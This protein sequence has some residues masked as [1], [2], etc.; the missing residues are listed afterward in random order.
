MKLLLLSIFLFSIACSKE[1]PEPPHVPT[2][3]EKTAQCLPNYQE[4]TR[5]SLSI[6]GKIE[7]NCFQNDLDNL[8]SA[9]EVITKLEQEVKTSQNL[10]S[11][12]NN[13][14]KLQEILAY[15]RTKHI[16]SKPEKG[17][18]ISDVTFMQVQGDIFSASAG[19]GKGFGGEEETLAH[20]KNAL[21]SIRDQLKDHAFIVNEQQ[22]RP[23][24]NIKLDILP[25]GQMPYPDL[26]QTLLN[27]LI[28]NYEN[29]QKLMELFHDQTKLTELRTEL[30]KQLGELDSNQSL[31]LPGGWNGHAVNYQ[32]T[33][34]DDAS[35]TFRVYNEGGGIGEYHAES[36]TGYKQQYF[37]FVEVRGIA[38]ENITSFVFLNLLQKIAIEAGS[39]TDFYELVLPAIDGKQEPVT[40]DAKLFHDMQNAGTC[41]YFSTPMVMENTVSQM[42]DAETAS[43]QFIAPQIE[44]LINAKTIR[45][46]A[47]IANL[48]LASRLNLL[49]KGLVYFS[50]DTLESSNRYVIDAGTLAAANKIGS[51]IFEQIT[52]AQNNLDSNAKSST[53]KFSDTSI[54]QT[55]PLGNTHGSVSNLRKISDSA[56][57]NRI[58]PFFEIKPTLDL[59]QIFEELHKAVTE[60]HYVEVMDATEKLALNLSL[61]PQNPKEE[62]LSY[63]AKI[64]EIYLFA[65]LKRAAHP[66]NEKRVTAIQFLTSLTLLSVGDAINQKLGTGIDSLY[67]AR[68][69]EF[70]FGDLSIFEIEDPKWQWQLKLL[71]DYYRSEHQKAGDDYLSFYG[72][73][74]LPV[75]VNTHRRIYE[76]TPP[77]KR[78]D[79]HWGLDIKWK[80]LDWAL[81]YARKNFAGKI[82]LAEQTSPGKITY[83]CKEPELKE[84]QV[85][86]GT[87]NTHESLE[88]T[89]RISEY[90]TLRRIAIES[91]GLYS[92]HPLPKPFYDLRKLSGITDY[93][94]TA[95]IIRDTDPKDLDSEFY[96]SQKK[97]ETPVQES[98][99]V[100]QAG[101]LCQIGVG[102]AQK[103]PILE[104]M[105]D[106]YVDFKYYVFFNQKHSRTSYEPENL[107]EFPEDKNQNYISPYL[108]LK[109]ASKP[110]EKFKSTQKA[111]EEIVRLYGELKRNR[112]EP[113]KLIVNKLNGLISK[114]ISRERARAILGIS[115]FKN[116]Q[117]IQ[118]LAYFTRYPNLLHLPV[119]QRLFEKLILDPGLLLSQL[120]NNSLL[121][122][123]LGKFTQQ[124][125]NNFH[126]IGD[127]QGMAF[128]LRINQLFR[129]YANFSRVNTAN[130]LMD[131]R[132]KLLELIET[133]KD[134]QEISFLYRNL[135][136][137]Y[138]YETHLSPL[139][140]QNL[141]LAVMKHK[142][143]PITNPDY[144]DVFS[145]KSIENILISHAEQILK[146]TNNSMLNF[147]ASSLSNRKIE[148]N[149]KNTS[150]GVYNSSDNRLTISVIRGLFL[151]SGHTLTAFPVPLEIY[152]KAFGNVKPPISATIL[153]DNSSYSWTWKGQ[154]QA[155]GREKDKG[156][157]IQ[158]EQEDGRWFELLSDSQLKPLEE[159]QAY[160]PNTAYWQ[161]L[162]SKDGKIHIESNNLEIT[163]NGQE[164]ELIQRKNSSSPYLINV[165]EKSP[166]RIFEHIE[167]WNK[168]YLWSKDKKEVDEVE[169]P[170]LKLAFKVQNGRLI[171]GNITDHV[172]STEQFSQSLSEPVS[173]LLCEPKSNPEQNRL[174]LTPLNRPALIDQTK[175]NEQTKRIAAFNPLF[176][177]NHG[178][179]EYV[180]YNINDSNLEQRVLPKTDTGRYY[181][182]LRKFYQHQ[183][184]DAANLIRS[185]ASELGVFTNSERLVLN[186]IAD[187]NP[188]D[189]DPRAYAISLL[190]EAWLLKDQVYYQGFLGDKKS[191]ERAKAKYLEYLKRVEHVDRTLLGYDNEALIASLLERNQTQIIA[192]LEPKLNKA[193]NELKNLAE[194]DYTGRNTKKAEIKNLE[195]IITQLKKQQHQFQSRSSAIRAEKA[196]R[197]FF[198]T[199]L[200]YHPTETKLKLQTAYWWSYSIRDLEPIV[201]EDDFGL[202]YQIV[203]GE[204][205][206]HQQARNWLLKTLGFK[207][208]QVGFL[209]S[210]EL[211]AEVMLWLRT[212]V[213]AEGYGTPQTNAYSFLLSLGFERI[214]NRPHKRYKAMKSW[215]IFKHEL[216][217]AINIC[218]E[219]IQLSLKTGRCDHLSAVQYMNDV[220]NYF[221]HKIIPTKITIT[222]PIGLGQPYL[223]E[224]GTPSQEIL[225]SEVVIIAEDPLRNPLLST[226]DIEQFFTVSTITP[227]EQASDNQKLAELTRQLAK[228]KS[229]N[230]PDIIRTVKN[231]SER[232]TKFVK[233]SQEN[234]KSY[235][236]KNWRELEALPILNLSQRKA[237]LEKL[238]EEILSQGR[239]YAPLFSSG[240]QQQTVHRADMGQQAELNEL[241]HMFLKRSPLP[242]Y[243]ISGAHDLKALDALYNKLANYLIE[244]T[245]VKQITKLKEAITSKNIEDTLEFGRESRQYNPKDHVEYLVFEYYMNLL[246]RK[247]QVEA[248][249]LLQIKDG[250]IRNERHYGALIEMIMGSGKTLVLLPMLSVL[251]TPGQ[252]LNIIMLPEPLIADE[253]RKLSKKLGSSFARGIDVLEFSRQRY[254]GADDLNR[255]Y[256]RLQ[257]AREESR[258]IVTTNSAMQSLFLNFVGRLS[259]Q[260]TEEIAPFIQIFKFLKQYGRL[261]IDEVDLALDILQSHQFSIGKSISLTDSSNLKV[262][263][264][265]AI[266]FYHLLATDPVLCDKI[267][268]SFTHC[269]KNS[270]TQFFTQNSY[271]S[272]KPILIN[273]ILKA[274]PYFV[275]Y[276]DLEVRF[277]AIDKNLAREYLT[278]GDRLVLDKITDNTA[279]NILAVLYEEIQAVFPLTA[280]KK[281][282]VQYGP[283]DSDL[284]AIPYHLGTPMKQSRFGT[285]LEALN[286]TLQMVLESRNFEPILSKE[287]AYLDR[288][289]KTKPTFF[290][291]KFEELGLAGHYEITRI[292]KQDI[293]EIAQKI[294]QPSEIQKQFAL[295]KSQVLKQVRVYPR[296]LVTNAQ[297]YEALFKSVQGLSGTLWN[298][299]T[300]PKIF[301]E[302]EPSTTSEE[303]F[304]TLWRDQEQNAVNLVTPKISD[305][306]TH[307]F[308]GSLIDEAGLFVAH[309][310]HEIAKEIHALTAQKI[311]YYDEANAIKTE[312][313]GTGQI[314]DFAAY[315]DK[316]HT[317]GSD[318]KLQKNMQARMTVDQHTLS[319]NLQQAAWRLR[320]LAKGQKINAFCLTAESQ[321]IMNTRLEEWG[322]K[323]PRAFELGDIILYVVANQETRLGD[324]RVR[325]AKQKIK[326]VIVKQVIHQI[327]SSSSA[328][329][330]LKAYQ[331]GSK[332]FEVNIE[333]SEL[334]QQLGY[335]IKFMS[336]KFILD[337]YEASLLRDNKTYDSLRSEI[338]DLIKQE[339]PKLPPKVLNSTQNSEQ[340]V[341]I[342]SEQETELEAEQ[343]QEVEQELDYSGEPD[344]QPRKV[345]SWNLGPLFVLKNAPVITLEKAFLD[346]GEEFLAHAFDKNILISRNFAPKH[347]VG[348]YAYE[349]FGLYHKVL[350]DVLVLQDA[351]KTQVVILD[352]NDT[353]EWDE[354]LTPK[355]PIRAA[356][357]NLDLGFYKEGSEPIQGNHYEST[358]AQVK[359]FAGVLNYNQV[360]Q[361]YLETFLRTHNPK[362]MLEIFRKEILKHRR[363]TR[364]NFLGSD[365]AGI[366]LKIL[367]SLD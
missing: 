303:T 39:D 55:A 178:S 274:Q 249:D 213:R 355:P 261:T 114:D 271:K 233:N 34:Q 339:N 244:S 298:T 16:L 172:V 85:F 27:K 205:F 65:L 1:K 217:D 168:V 176:G 232:I 170:R 19:A 248:L 109:N 7:A 167:N 82:N 214:N 93:L 235:Q 24:L 43:S 67:Q 86:R 338:Q 56:E 229:S 12:A 366:F 130:L 289:S 228:A 129:D 234:Q 227:L 208:A 147:L 357:Y 44:F 150:K 102:A 351:D 71:Q 90:N 22:S 11:I 221:E 98:K 322:M 209:S 95:P 61:N 257:K 72:F 99:S 76:I 105:N 141:V 28:K 63:L 30:I 18:A 127:L 267:A 41:V 277:E 318:L 300:Y 231:L 45:D 120:Q 135:A 256:A 154:L 26:S 136:E 155:L 344:Y 100:R 201:Q 312:P 50:R 270:Q 363:D 193:E 287:I 106:P 81:A 40:Y 297:V 84:G 281:L 299:D 332:L 348:S 104:S 352:G 25:K 146:N 251:N 174:A 107:V 52:K 166:Y 301:R 268:F 224:I 296:Q 53:P 247:N 51:D 288:L 157:V 266:S 111:H 330:A 119:Y 149:W 198:A 321:G 358:I 195:K 57:S 128:A 180:L 101:C 337:E 152:E 238:R 151:D 210:S 15:C 162:D 38:Y 123:H 96:I 285:S 365:L 8:A 259:D 246:I 362:K 226:Y 64:D 329:D 345:P 20:R 308:K 13:Y 241:I 323:P 197:E 252:W 92:R 311:A 286:Y 240:A 258:T 190:A 340:E 305:I 315:W 54:K 161:Q 342:E 367:G 83:S 169:L 333:K 159:T 115:G 75:G 361:H 112:Q 291:K 314:E 282:D 276:P 326:N 186:W 187:G 158:R 48:S 77:P 364:E 283:I 6:F 255:L 70:L 196:N 73:E 250:Q 139:D 343:E 46:Y 331:S 356:L 280:S 2:E 91:L 125:Y 58:K 306:Y 243:M 220:T 262:L 313:E 202:L 219:E 206:N 9:R 254:L 184:R 108:H 5:N 320:G 317:T 17:P 353:R 194:T 60:E 138:L 350:T 79:S 181:L 69:G 263:P 47:G 142:L 239:Q 132:K 144:Y 269:P 165:P 117:I 260:K 189:Q 140:V 242:F 87:C 236:V 309:T 307:E 349:F 207:N 199:P 354:F 284:I 225:D 89:S 265:V 325:A 49:R 304:W 359:F 131:S 341:E 279:K 116:Q 42:I 36:I 215:H 62:D 37:P 32:I 66:E 264:A 173:Y 23:C 273:Q 134:T 122:S 336:S 212:Q 160:F 346:H 188:N 223:P 145:K 175:E 177:F 360:Q 335:P 31:F 163:L 295:I 290:K 80:D 204:S 218:K 185:N 211:R 171:C 94:L 319:R 3:E 124:A 59:K 203:S 148:D 230:N 10:K 328:H 310:N 293:T 68:S 103:T 216:S 110:F 222:D 164:I 97:G 179:S 327:L 118:T 192:D 74:K 183:Y 324:L 35:Y 78:Q 191:L 21:S 347:Q 153:G 4:Q 121:V 182:A 245:T 126:D 302:F 272:L 14:Q 278:S 88:P 294:S 143:L 156:W 334:Y 200:I 316:Q 137:S 133:R 275:G 253:S 113:N 29:A 292:S 33:K 237:K